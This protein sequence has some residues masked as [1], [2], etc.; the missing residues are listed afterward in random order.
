MFFKP[1]FYLFSMIVRRQNAYERNQN[2]KQSMVGKLFSKYNIFLLFLFMK[3]CEWYFSAQ[4]QPQ[5]LAAQQKKT[6]ILKPPE[7]Y[8]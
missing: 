5:T 1:Y 4:Q 2:A 8:S 6:S 3:F 7:D